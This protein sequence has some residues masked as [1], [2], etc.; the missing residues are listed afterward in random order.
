[1]SSRRGSK[2]S[3]S[4]TKVS[5]SLLKSPFSA[6]NLPRDGLGKM[7]TL[8]DDQIA[9]LSPEVKQ[10][11]DLEHE[12][13]AESFEND[14]EQEI[15]VESEH[16]MD[17]SAPKPIITGPHRYTPKVTSYPEA[18]KPL[19]RYNPRSSSFSKVSSELNEI[20]GLL[21]H[22]A[23]KSDVAVSEITRSVELEHSR[24]S[25][26]SQQNVKTSV[27]RSSPQEDEDEEDAPRDASRFMGQEQ[28]AAQ[29]RIARHVNES[30]KVGYRYVPSPDNSPVWSPLASPGFNSR[31]IDESLVLENNKTIL[32]AEL[33]QILCAARQKHEQV[34]TQNERQPEDVGERAV[35]EVRFLFR[36]CSISYQVT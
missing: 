31:R 34:Q 15:V 7:R 14:T 8:E 6:D 29:W 23:A 22:Y 35:E 13:D 4:S 33:G 10:E 20:D 18:P 3:E 11:Y 36:I 12:Y 30:G 24:V 16:V 21:A 1:M 27:A 5:R 28:V 17:F 32:K 25:R 2:S 9:L 19:H 26:K